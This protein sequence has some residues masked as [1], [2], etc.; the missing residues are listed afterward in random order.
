VTDALAADL[1]NGIENVMLTQSQAS[2]DPSKA[3]G[4]GFVFLSYSTKDKALAGTLKSELTASGFEVFLA[5]EDLVPSEEWQQEIL[6]ALQ[7]CDVFTPLLTEN[8]RGSDWTDQEVGLALA[9]VSGCVILSL[10]VSPVAS[11]H[12]FLKPY[13]ALKL[14]P[15]RP[16]PACRAFV[17]VIG[18]KLGISKVR[19]NRAVQQF[20]SS[21]SFAAAKRNVRALLEFDSLSRDQ[22]DRILTAAITN[23]QV[24][25]AYR[26]SELLDT[27]VA[28]HNASPGPLQQFLRMYHP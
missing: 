9:R 20:V 1:R 4:D 5:H 13:Q 26:V 25:R 18:E 22:M 21:S 3:P 10:M 23:N 16:E 12:A 17:K 7:R 19:K 11:P 6:R 15:K 14:D 28:R 24:Y 2:E 27:L 8:F